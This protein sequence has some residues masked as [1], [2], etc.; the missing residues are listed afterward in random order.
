MD[1][2]SYL[3]QGQLVLDGQHPLGQRLAG[4]GTNYVGSENFIGLVHDDLDH[5]GG[6]AFANRTVQARVRE[7]MLVDAI[8]L[9][10]SA[11]LCN[12]HSYMGNLRVSECHPR[13]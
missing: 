11:G 8:V 12:R 5:S 10:C 9:C 6:V 1:R 3:R 4:T 13:E 2:A 7:Y